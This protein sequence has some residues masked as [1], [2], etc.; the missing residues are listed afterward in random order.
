MTNTFDKFRSRVHLSTRPTSPN[1]F[2]GQIHPRSPVDESRS[3]NRHKIMKLQLKK[4]CLAANSDLSWWWGA[5]SSSGTRSTRSSSSGTSSALASWAS[6]LSRSQAGWTMSKCL[7]LRRSRSGQMY[8]Y[9]NQ[10]K[11]SIFCK[12]DRVQVSW[13]KVD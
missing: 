13:A 10:Q 5:S 4:S 6:T 2:N 9:E 7:A 8:E 3:P 12:L 11:F 1:S